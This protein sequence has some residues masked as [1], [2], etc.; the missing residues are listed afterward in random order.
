M[1]RVL[2]AGKWV[3]S[4]SS[5]DF[6]KITNFPMKFNFPAFPMPGQKQPHI[7]SLWRNAPLNRWGASVMDLFDTVLYKYAYQ[8]SPFAFRWDSFITLANIYQRKLSSQSKFSIFNE[9]FLNYIHS[10]GRKRKCSFCVRWLDYHVDM[11]V[12][13]VITITINANN[14]RSTYAEGNFHSECIIPFLHIK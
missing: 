11:C 13:Y 8:S 6:P 9:N 12:V 10:G 14:V 1:L 2:H 5:F 7:L 3:L 4:R